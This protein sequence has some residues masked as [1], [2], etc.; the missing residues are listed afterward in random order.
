MI[1]QKS[2]EEKKHERM[3]LI[4]GLPNNYH[5]NYV[6]ASRKLCH[7]CHKFI[8]QNDIDKN[9]LV[10]CIDEWEFYHK[11]CIEQLGM[12]VIHQRPNDKA[13]T[14]KLIS[15]NPLDICVKVDGAS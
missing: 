5:V 12:V 11:K 13:S 14:A 2:S 1:E 4:D 8:Q 10:C 6:L 3:G 15:K 7:I 9:H